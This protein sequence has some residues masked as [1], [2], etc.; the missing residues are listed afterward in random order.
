MTRLSCFC[1]L[2]LACAALAAEDP[3][4]WHAANAR[5]VDAWTQAARKQH[6]GST[7][8]WIERGVVADRGAGRVEFVAEATGID[9]GAI[10]EFMVVGE[11]SEKDY[12][13]LTVSFARSSDL[14]RAL[15][16][17]GVPR[18]RP[19]K[20]AICRF[21]PKGERVK[22]TVRQLG[23]DAGAAKPLQECLHDKR[24][25]AIVPDNYVYV[26]SSWTGTVCLA[27]EGVPGA[28]ISTYN[29]PAVVLDSPQR[30]PQGEVYGN[31]VVSS[32]GKFENGT[33]LLIVLTPDPLPN[34]VSRTIDVTFEARRRAG[35]S[36]EGL[37]V[38]ECV[39]RSAEPAF[40]A[41]TNDVK[42]A[43]LRLSG[44]NKVGRDP[45]VDVLFDDSL[46]VGTA[47]D[48]ARVLAMVEGMSGLRI[49][50]PLPNQLYY[51]AYLPDERWRPRLDRPS[52]PWELRVG[53]G[54][55]GAWSCTLVQILEDWS[56]EGQLTPD[57]TPTEYP[58]ARPEDL[59]SKIRELVAAQVADV[60]QKLKQAGK[61]ADED[62]VDQ[63][64]TLKKINTIFVFAPPDA[65]L[66]TFLPA[67]RTVRE[68]LP[69]VHVFVE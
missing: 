46:S 69:Q 24:A 25:E 66:G 28:A 40:G 36:G 5:A 63:M 32:T 31:L 38:V 57:L 15:E 41:E 6:A 59:P 34:G 18:G 17:L 30:S 23:R 48:L 50:A 4:P 27:D 22:A 3:K 62:R 45:F 7:N 1:V 35:A 64:A 53:R 39:T 19:V 37:G 58:L 14:C 56:K 26:G 43:L 21:W 29:E 16:F 13:S 44:I 8:V 54:K 61:P 42:G 49:E 52:Q 51:K 2:A 10:T 67:V 65:P 11:K 20:P 68:T 12:E 33:L 9:A 55:D 47:R 60:K